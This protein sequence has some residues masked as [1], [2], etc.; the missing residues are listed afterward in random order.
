MLSLPPVVSVAV[1]ATVPACV[2]SVGDSAAVPQ[3]ARVAARQ[4]VRQGERQPQTGAIPGVPNGGQHRQRASLARR[5]AYRAVRAPSRRGLQSSRPDCP[6]SSHGQSPRRGRV[7]RRTWHVH[8]LRRLGP[9]GRGHPPTPTAPARG[10]AAHR[11]AR[12]IR[13]PLQRAHRAASERGPR[14]GAS[15]RGSAAPQE[16]RH[17]RGRRVRGRHCARRGRRERAGCTASSPRS[18]TTGRDDR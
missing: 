18:R 11:A 13:L 10:S 12:R 14:R 5:H 4:A 7:A 17:T 1:E 8:G 6:R 16:R 9:G 3:T 2:S 15:L